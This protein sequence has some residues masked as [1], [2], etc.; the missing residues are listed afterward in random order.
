[1]CDSYVYGRSR[2]SAYESHILRECGMSRQTCTRFNGLDHRLSRLAAVVEKNSE[3]E[4]LTAE[5]WEV[6][7]MQKRL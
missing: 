7:G 3:R 5:G 4:A 1:M 6:N 2:T